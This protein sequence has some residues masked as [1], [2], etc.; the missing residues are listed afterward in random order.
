MANPQKEEWF[1]KIYY[2]IVDS[3]LWA[4]LS[5]KARSVYVVLLRYASWNTGVCMPTQ[6]TIANL[7]GI[8]RSSIPMATKELE[9]KG[10]IKVWMKVLY[11]RKRLYYKVIEPK[12]GITPIN[13]TLQPK[14]IVKGRDLKTGK[15]GRAMSDLTTRNVG[16]NGGV[17]TDNIGIKRDIRKRDSKENNKESIVNTLFSLFENEHKGRITK[18]EIKHT[19]MAN[20]GEDPWIAEQRAKMAIK[21]R[22]EPSSDWWQIL[23]KEKV[24]I[25][26][27]L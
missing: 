4:N 19:L 15:F 6:K 3:G 14:R 5:Y 27:I 24:K 26:N 16:F 20:W 25:D 12:E 13:T 21:G 1:G 7:S 10:L 11:G 18:P 17:I 9:I 2:Q 22:G 8:Y 23:M